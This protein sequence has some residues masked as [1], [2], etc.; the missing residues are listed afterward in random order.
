MRALCTGCTVCRGR[1]DAQERR[2]PG[3][4]HGLPSEYRS[5]RDRDDSCAPETPRAASLS[6]RKR[7][8]KKEFKWCPGPESNRYSRRPRDFKS[9]VS[10]N[11]T[12]GAWWIMLQRGA[13]KNGGWSRN[14]TGVH[15]VAVRC[16]TT[17]PSSHSRDLVG[18][19]NETRT[20]DPDLGKVV[21]YQLSYSR[22]VSTS[23][24]YYRVMFRCVNKMYELFLLKD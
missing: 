4:A 14:R 7:G 2:P 5:A 23:G 24:A 11:F 8:T 18:A 16:M 6:G 17:L 15:G 19:G 12:T 20:R 3:E 10:T 21:L 13:E 22:G 1:M 9:L